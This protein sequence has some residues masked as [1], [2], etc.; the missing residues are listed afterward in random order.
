[1]TTIIN[2]EHSFEYE[3]ECYR[4]RWLLDL[5]INTINKQAYTI[6]NTDKLQRRVMVYVGKYLMDDIDNIKNKAHIRRMV[7]GKIK[8]SIGRYGTQEALYYEE[9]SSEDE[10]TSKYEPP[11]ILANVENIVERRNNLEYLIISLAGDD[12]RAR[13]ALTALASGYNDV[14][15]ASILADVYGGKSTGHRS[16]IKRFKKECREALTV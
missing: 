7:C 3:S 14:E 11:D 16:F 5:I 1:M 4:H 13:T 9:F 8:E 6:T 15:T 10:K 2:I 12:L